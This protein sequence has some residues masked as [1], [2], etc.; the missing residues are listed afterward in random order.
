MRKKLLSGL[1]WVLLA[2]LFVKPF[3]ILG[4]E[5]GV[6]NAVGAQTYGFYFAVMNLAYIFNILLDMGVTNFNTRN[7][8]RNSQLIQKHLSGIL[9]IKLLL[10]VLYAVVTFTVGLMLGYHSRQFYLLAWLCLNQFLNSLIVYLRSN[11][12]GLLMFKIDSLLSVLDRILMIIICGFLLWG[13]MRR[14]PFRIEWFVY[15]QTVAYLFSALVAL[16]ALGKKV[17]LH[18][19]SWNRPFTFVIL[20]KSAPFALLVLLMASYNRIDPVLLE[21]LLPGTGDYEAGIYAASFRLLDALT[22]IAYLVSVLLLPIYSK[23]TKE[24]QKEQTDRMLQQ[25]GEQRQNVGT[26]QLV[27]TVSE[28][29]NKE[30]KDITQ[31]IF[32]LM[33]VVTVSIALTC[34]YF[35]DNLMNL[36]Y[37]EHI[38]EIAKVFRII[39]LGFI[40]IGFTYVFGTL[41]TANG[42]LKQ[43]NL[44]AAVSL[45]LNVAVNLVCIPRWGAL[46][47]AMASLTAQS[48]IGL[49]QMILA[50]KMFHFRPAG[51]YILRLA[52]FIAVVWSAA[53]ILSSVAAGRYSAQRQGVILILIMGVLAIVTAL[54]LRL[55]D[56]RE[57]K[58]ILKENEENID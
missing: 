53:W 41:L 42:N 12:E 20:K 55:I 7:I 23:L 6:Q 46:G 36:L 34:T 26:K 45:A 2:N 58:T 21:R 22:M 57:I 31:M 9:T 1:F 47:A 56:I 38:D 8:A 28:P 49:A 33:F 39:I 29:A 35:S 10:L 18:K 51:S 3:W 25:K 13:P 11:F 17:G 19:L 40:P 5:V 32:S 54:L 48:F 16:V 52:A 50:G 27:S 14:T 30:L 15:A 4:I 44:F 43:L 24:V 37:H